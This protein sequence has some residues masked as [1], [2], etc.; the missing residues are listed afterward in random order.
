MTLDLH[1]LLKHFTKK[2]TIVVKRIVSEQTVEKTVIDW[3]KVIGV[4]FLSAV[5]I[6]GVLERFGFVTIS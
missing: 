5:I 1:P 4:P 2:K 3:D 6:L